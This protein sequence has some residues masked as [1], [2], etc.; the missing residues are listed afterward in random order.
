MG[1]AAN[2]L[3]G[4][5]LKPCIFVPPFVSPRAAHAHVLDVHVT[6]YVKHGSRS[7]RWHSNVKMR[8]GALIWDALDPPHETFWKDPLGPWNLETFGSMRT[9]EPFSPLTLGPWNPEILYPLDPEAFGF[10]K[11]HTL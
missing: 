1:T 3:I 5:A 4:H 9:R 2:H 11:R 6:L 8:V 7:I 10:W